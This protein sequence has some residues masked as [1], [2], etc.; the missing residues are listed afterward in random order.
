MPLTPFLFF[1]SSESPFRVVSFFFLYLIFP[2]ILFLASH[3]VPLSLL[4]S[5]FFHLK[6]TKRNTQHNNYQKICTF[7]FCLVSVTVY[8]SI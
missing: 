1:E 3:P 6:K 8:K 4:F 2:K 7:L 5:P